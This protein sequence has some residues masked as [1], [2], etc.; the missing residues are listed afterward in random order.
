MQTDLKSFFSLRALHRDLLFNG[1]EA[2]G[3]IP[4]NIGLLQHG[5]LMLAIVGETVADVETLED[6]VRHR[7]RGGKARARGLRRE[8]V[9]A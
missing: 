2:A 1:R 9:A 7:A 4:Y 6:E 3:I 5:K 8:R